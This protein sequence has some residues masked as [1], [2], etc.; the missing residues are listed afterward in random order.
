MG[1]FV[2]DQVIY[3]LKLIEFFIRGVFGSKRALNHL[4]KTTAIVIRFLLFRMN[5]SCGTS[6]R[7]A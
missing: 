5:H 2:V 7:S 1:V 4:L 6:S 3:Y